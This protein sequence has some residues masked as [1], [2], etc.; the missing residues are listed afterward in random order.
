MR[1]AAL[2]SMVIT[3]V[4]LDALMLRI[5]DV[6][7]S[8]RVA[9]F[10]EFE[11]TVSA[12][13]LSFTIRET[14]LASSL[15]DRDSSVRAA[16]LSLMTAWAASVAWD[17][18]DFLALFSLPQAEQPVV[19]LLFKLYEQA[20][21]APPPSN[22]VTSRQSLPDYCSG[23]LLPADRA[24]DVEA[25]ATPECQVGPRDRWL[26]LQKIASYTPWGSGSTDG[27]QGPNSVSGAALSVPSVT[28]WQARCTWLRSQGKLPAAERKLTPAAAEEQLDAL[29]PSLTSVCRMLLDLLDATQVPGD[30][31]SQQAL[32]AES[33]GVML[34]LLRLGQACD[35][36]DSV[37]ATHIE[38]LVPSLL[39]HKFSG[40]QDS[41]LHSSVMTL[42]L[43]GDC[44]D[45]EAVRTLIWQGG[46][47]LS[48][49]TGLG[50]YI[51][52][53]AL[54]QALV[55][56]LFCISHHSEAKLAEII[57]GCVMELCEGSE[58]AETPE[59]AR[60]LHTF[61]HFLA[62]TGAPLSSTCI[63]EA[64]QEVVIPVLGSSEPAIASLAL[65]CVA[66]AGLLSQ[67][68][69]EAASVAADF[70]AMHVATI[71]QGLGSSSGL[72]QFVALEAAVDWL[73]VLEP[74]SMA[75]EAS[76]VKH[77][78][79]DVQFGHFVL[80]QLW[81]IGN[82]GQDSAQRALAL[83]GLSKLLFQGRLPRGSVTESD[84]VALLLVMYCTPTN[85]AADTESAGEDAAVMRS[86]QCMATFLPNLAMVAQANRNLIAVSFKQALELFVGLLTPSMKIDI[87][88]SLLLMAEFTIFLLDVEDGC[89]EPCEAL[90]SVSPGM[91]VAACLAAAF[92]KQA[93]EAT[94]DAF[95]EVAVN[96]MSRNFDTR[97]SSSSSWLR[98]IGAQLASYAPS[99]AKQRKQLEQV[100]QGEATTGATETNLADSA[101]EIAIQNFF[102]GFE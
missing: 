56:L 99:Q 43:Y 28:A 31:A 81:K 52:G 78:D 15:R 47:N 61:G 92:S 11:H 4:T 77:D 88:K 32:A 45:D 1:C 50:T 34:Q 44:T 69:P 3:A 102:G 71:A 97:S 17:A 35:S 64:M 101:E 27:D 100:L 82:E 41:E 90:P 95:A 19:G 73:C 37:G 22:K 48:Q 66:L 14:L 74:T 55:D 60:A 98:F 16:G 68:N 59:C 38:K 87:Q 42:A 65:R 89:L 96:I 39:V 75:L 20:L 9:A 30:E 13:A 72:T 40:G 83:E 23:F 76:L 2:G 18:A 62:C 26:G 8:V 51:P 7:S 63:S 5:N 21:T 79:D 70:T 91:F 84:V 46:N 94:S 29:A 6:D 85:Q 54:V 80:K 25:N 10:R 49:R 33:N 24:G 58:S 67:P 57:C 53:G 36:S 93:S 12:S 86:K